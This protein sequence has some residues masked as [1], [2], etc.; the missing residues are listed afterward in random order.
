MK[1]I[2]A[3]MHHYGWVKRPDYQVEKRKN[4]VRYWNSDNWM[5]RN[6]NKVNQFSYDEASALK[7]F[8]DTHPAVMKARIARVDWIV[9]RA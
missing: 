3:W 8:E 7:R 4:F 5:L 1:E 6:S 2:D 9:L